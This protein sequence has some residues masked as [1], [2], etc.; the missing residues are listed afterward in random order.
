MFALNPH[1][2]PHD[3]ILFVRDA[4]PGDW[5]TLFIA[6]LLYRDRLLPVDLQMVLPAPPVNWDAYRFVFDWNGESLVL[7]KSIR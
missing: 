5:T 3:R 4:F 1:L 2:P 7:L 6:R